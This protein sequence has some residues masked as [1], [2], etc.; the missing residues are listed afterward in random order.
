MYKDV[1]IRIWPTLDQLLQCLVITVKHNLLL[2][3]KKINYY[4]AIWQLVKGDQVSHYIQDCTLFG[5]FSFY[6]YYLCIANSVSLFIYA[7]ETGDTINFLYFLQ[8]L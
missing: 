7:T 3:F 8:F 2:C 6:F 1:Q 4:N 5:V